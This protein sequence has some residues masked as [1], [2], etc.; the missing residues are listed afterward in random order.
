MSIQG[1]QQHVKPA[2]QF[3]K[4]GGNVGADLELDL[5]TLFYI[6]MQPDD[7]LVLGRLA[8]QRARVYTALRSEKNG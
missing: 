4:K 7:L 8:I 6:G 3:L 2:V 5:F 1:V